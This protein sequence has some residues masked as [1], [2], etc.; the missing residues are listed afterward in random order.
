MAEENQ[1]GQEKTEHATPKR[2]QEARD[3]GQVVR[4]RELST[5]AVLMVASISFYIT[6]GHMLKD[7]ETMMHEFLTIQRDSAFDSQTIPLALLASIEDFLLM[8]LPFLMIM[9]VISLLSPLALGGWS[10][11]AKA[12]AFKPERLDPIKGLSRVFSKRGLVE[13]LKAL[14]KFA[15]VTGMAGTFI[16]IH[17]NELLLVGS[18][19]V[20]QGLVQAVSLSLQAFLVIGISTVLIALVDVPFQLWDNANK[21]KMTKQEVKEEMKQTEGRPEVRSRIR[22]LQQE[23][24]SRR[25][26][27]E[28]PKADVIV[29]NPDHYAVALR[30]EQ[31]SMGAPRMLAKGVNETAA[32]IRDLGSEHA[33]TLLRAPPL[34]RALYFSTRIGDEIPEGLYLA[35]AQ[36]LAYVYRLREQKPGE[37][38]PPQPV[39]LP[40]PDELRRDPA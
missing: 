6:G 1:D 5:M 34:A 2:E 8:V 25:M 24:A 30:Y 15:L 3:D 33:I 11:S 38:T 36:V 26:M 13:L 27:E 21:L 40:I 12:M 35:V 18:T 19:S 7:I 4:S 20:H 10:L 37:E 28:V 16:W 32:R 23:V 17:L 29:T 31:G 14:A 22:A 9:L 39:D